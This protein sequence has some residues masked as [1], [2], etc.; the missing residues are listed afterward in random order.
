VA[1]QYVTTG[2]K[3]RNAVTSHTRTPMAGRRALWVQG[4]GT[5]AGARVC[6]NNLSGALIEWLKPYYVAMQKR[7]G[8]G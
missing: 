5:A 1:G 2:R 6:V 7:P 3:N 8:I 4:T